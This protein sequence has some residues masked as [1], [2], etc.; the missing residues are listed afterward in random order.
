MTIL[1]CKKFA[2]KR[3]FDISRDDIRRLVSEIIEV[4]HE[5]WREDEL[6]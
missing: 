3:N 2:P 5:R 4:E 6:D 1:A